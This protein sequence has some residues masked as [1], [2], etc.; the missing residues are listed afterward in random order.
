MLSEFSEAKAQR[1]FSPQLRSSAER[2]AVAYRKLF[3]THTFKI[4]RR[5]QVFFNP[6]VNVLSVEKLT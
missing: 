4:A 3:F 1:R 5:L 2:N 6:W